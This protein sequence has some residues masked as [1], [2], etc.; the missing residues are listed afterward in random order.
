MEVP[1][2]GLGRYPHISL[3]DFLKPKEGKNGNWKDKEQKM[4]GNKIYEDAWASN[5]FL[6]SLK[7]VKSNYLSSQP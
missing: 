5:A 3:K 2:A 4:V 1:L 7:E 6:T